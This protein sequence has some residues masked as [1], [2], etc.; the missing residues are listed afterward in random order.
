[1]HGVRAILSRPVIYSCFQCLMGG[2]RGRTTFVKDFIRPFPGM[3]VLDIGCGPADILRYLRDVDYFGFDINDAYIH[4][5]RALYGQ[6]AK[7]ESR[8]LV[9]ADVEKMPLFDAVLAQGLIHHLDDEA[10]IRMMKLA[11]KALKPEGRFLT[12]DPCLDF[13]QDPIAR[14]LVSYDRGQHVRNKTGYTSLAQLVFKSARIEIRHQSW[15][16]Y[17]H[18]YMECTRL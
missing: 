10:A 15:I 8:E 9:E 12:V 13:G 18:C 11:Y 17:T 5:A 16:P 6:R 4:R 3:T 7:F 2:H 1:M 14:F